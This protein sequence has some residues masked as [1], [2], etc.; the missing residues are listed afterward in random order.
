MKTKKVN[1]YECD[2]CHKRGLSASHMA[3]HESSC[4]MNPNRKC[5]VCAMGWGQHAP[6]ER[7]QKPIAELIALLPDPKDFAED[8]A[9]SALLKRQT[10]KVLPQLRAA[11]DNCPA[12]IMA[13]LRQRGIPVPLATDFNFTEEMKAIWSDINDAN[14]LACAY[15][16]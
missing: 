12:C 3:K 4:T 8:G 16:Q 6:N 9:L 10:N 13:A 11:C 5:R 1:R 14:T 2:F 15:D 7:D